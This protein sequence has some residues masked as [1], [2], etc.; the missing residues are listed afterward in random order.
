MSFL[1]ALFLTAAIASL[2]A[3][4]DLSADVERAKQ[5]AVDLG[6]EALNAGADILDTRSACLLAGQSA[7]LCGCLTERIGPDITAEHVEALTEMARA[8]VTGEATQTAA[9]TAPGI[10]AQSRD[11]IVQ[12]A[13][14]AAVEGAM[15]EAGN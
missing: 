15:T 2:V 12:C 6:Q 14:R 8:R 7:S 13:T 1:K 3:C 4:G 5:G 9:E 11:A 10:D